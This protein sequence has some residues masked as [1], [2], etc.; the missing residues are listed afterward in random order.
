MK[1]NFFW[2]N[3]NFFAYQPPLTSNILKGQTEKWKKFKGSILFSMR[4][5]KTIAAFLHLFFRV[6]QTFQ[7]IVSTKYPI[8][9]LKSNRNA[10]VLMETYNEAA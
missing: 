9:G 2:Q 7:L 4:T 5:L 6:R 8:E 10:V 1:K 3:S